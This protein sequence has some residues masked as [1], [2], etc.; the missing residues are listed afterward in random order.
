[1]NSESVIAI[2]S[3]ITPFLF[4]YAII[5]MA[6]KAENKKSEEKNIK[7]DDNVSL[8]ELEELTKRIE[9]LEI[10]INSREKRE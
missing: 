4:A 2:V 7:T 6:V 5:R 3:I 10:I 1:M 9:S 8:E